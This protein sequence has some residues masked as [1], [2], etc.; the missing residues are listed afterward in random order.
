MMKKAYENSLLI[1]DAYDGDKLV[2]FIRNV[3]DGFSIVIAQDII[4][5]PEYQRQGIAT[6]LLK[7]VM[8][9]FSSV[10]Q[11]ELMTDNTPKT[12]SFYQS[13]GFDRADDMGCCSFI[14]M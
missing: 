2:G 11:P 14:R 5:L 1:L 12:I 4:V 13:V 6:H 8:D 10:Y 3:G 7:K 9:R